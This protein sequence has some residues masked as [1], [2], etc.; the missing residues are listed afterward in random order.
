MK[1][2]MPRVAFR[3]CSICGSLQI[4]QSNLSRHMHDAHPYLDIPSAKRIMK[5]IERVI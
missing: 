1:T 4:Q 5:G 3:R 2:K